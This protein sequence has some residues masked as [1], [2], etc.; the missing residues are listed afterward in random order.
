MR[1]K[2]AL[3]RVPALALDST[4]FEAV[5]EAFALIGGVDDLCGPGKRILV[6]PNIAL[7]TSF[8]CTNPLVTLA[9]AQVF[10]GRRCEVILGE[11]SAIPA[12]EEDAYGFYHLREIADRAGAKVVSLRKGPQKKVAVPGGS[13]FSELEVSQIALEADAVVSAACMKSVNVT[14]VSLS[15]KNMKGVITNKW[16]RKFHCE[17]LNKGIVD[18]NRVVKPQLAVV[19]A[20]FAR[21]MVQRVCYPVGLI[22]AS[23]DALAADSICTRIM[24]FDPLE[25]EHLSLAAEAGL[26]AL[27]L[28]DIQVVGEKLEDHA[29][30]FPFAPP[31]DP[32]KLAAESDGRIEIVQGQPCSVCLNELGH[33]LSLYRDYL[34]DIEKVTILVGPKADPAKV[35]PDRHVVFYGNCLRKHD[36]K[37]HLV[38][39]CPPNEVLDGVTGTLQVP[40]DAILK[41]SKK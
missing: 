14:N 15:M 21:D 41:R 9:I 13:F 20:T 26:G 5:R 29:G 36:G 40:F 25:V 23:R 3:V 7:P 17:S 37:G 4:I 28:A 16:K 31:N 18:L 39:G 8:D 11:D 22:I 12:S 24:G 35:P 34:T 38:S 10:S 32:F 27:D 19:D 6:K 30:L 1:S 33:A 2:V